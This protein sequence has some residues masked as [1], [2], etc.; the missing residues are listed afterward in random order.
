MTGIY[1][2]INLIN[3]KRYIGQSIDIERRRK[4]HIQ[5]VGKFTTKISR[6]MAKYGVENFDFVVIEECSL[7]ELNQKESYWIHHYR[8]LD[9]RW[10]YNTTDVDEN[11]CIVVGQYNPNTK[12]SDADVI[13]IRHR[14]HILH[15]TLSEVYEDYNDRISYDS[16]WQA[17]H[18]KT[19]THLDTSMIGSLV[20]N[21]GQNNSRTKLT[22][23]DV[24]EIRN[25]I[26]IQQQE[27]LYVYQDYKDLIS[28]DAFRKLVKGETWT[29]IDCSMITN[30]S[31]QRKGLP[32]AK[33]TKEDVLKIRFEFENN[34]KT[35]E[36]LKKEYCYVTPVTIRRVVNYETWKNI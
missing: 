23:D 25:R 9:D 7:E 24:L 2:W 32:K 1:S 33:L 19:W 16:F 17:A 22:D 30:L 14:L 20:N 5:G 18:G 13:E 35:L 31:V 10:G 27:Q 4:Q 36:E 28:F 12:L 3:N 29:H 26:H 34:I 11:G 6:A 8:T 15:Q 21:K